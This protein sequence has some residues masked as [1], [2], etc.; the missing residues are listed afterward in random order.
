[1]YSLLL[2]AVSRT[3]SCTIS[4]LSSWLTFPQLLLLQPHVFQRKTVLFNLVRTYM[5]S[6]GI[7]LLTPICSARFHGPS[8]QKNSFATLLR[9]RVIMSIPVDPLISSRKFKMIPWIVFASQS[10]SHSRH[11][12]CFSALR[13]STIP[14]TDS[15]FEGVVASCIEGG[16]PSL[17]HHLMYPL[18]SHRSHPLVLEEQSV[19][20]DLSYT[21]IPSHEQLPNLLSQG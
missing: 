3:F 4:V 9:H 18:H 19:V 15:A 7:D 20:P 14:E 11:P 1:M 16:V 21:V 10:S 13:K 12:K 5:K 6:C 17:F 2:A 8:S